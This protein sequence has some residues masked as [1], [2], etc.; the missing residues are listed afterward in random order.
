MTDEKIIKAAK[1]FPTMAQAAESLGISFKVFKRRALQLGVYNPNRGGK[2]VPARRAYDKIPLKEILDGKHPTYQSR[3]LKLRLLKEGIFKD[4]CY[5]CGWNKKRI[6]DDF[7]TC[8]LHHVNGNPRDHK[9]ENLTILCP[10][11][12]SLTHN[13]RNL[14]RE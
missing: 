13:F 6:G 12:H 3:K 2:G 14:K 5:E 7:T 4:E 9:L 1:D 10:N 8:E 11:C